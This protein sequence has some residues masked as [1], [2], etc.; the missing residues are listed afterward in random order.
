[1][2]FRYTYDMQRG[3]RPRNLDFEPYQVWKWVEVQKEVRGEDLVVAVQL[4]EVLLWVVGVLAFVVE[5]VV[6]AQKTR[7]YQEQKL[8]RM[9]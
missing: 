5:T 2:R 1:M 4:L 7:F 8:P 3:L 6:A 9:D